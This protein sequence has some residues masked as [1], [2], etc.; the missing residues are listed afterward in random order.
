M[1]SY[2][3]PL[4]IPAPEAKPFWEYCKQH[5]LRMQKCSKCGKLRNPPNIICP[6]CHSMDFEWVKISGK[7]RVFSYVV[8]HYT[9]DK[10]WANDVPY[11]VASIELDEGPRIKSNIIE[12]K[13]E[14]VKI[15]MPVEIQFEDVT[16]E[17]TLY[18]FK[19]IATAK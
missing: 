16:N 1:D 2:E 11:I 8:Y 17:F 18:K 10:A 14:H 15:G 12:C 6:E 7:G 13:P 19:P 4:P 5:E 3:K 9:Y